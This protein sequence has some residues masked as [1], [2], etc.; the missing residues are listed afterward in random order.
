MIN[1][2]SCGAIVELDGKVLLVRQKN[3]EIL[4]FLKDISYLVKA[5]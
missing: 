3:Q 2:K 5:R 4:G 1:E